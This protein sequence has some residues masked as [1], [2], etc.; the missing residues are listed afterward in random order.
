MAPYSGIGA[1]P[2]STAVREG[3]ECISLCVLAMCE[4]LLGA[5]P[6]RILHGLFT[7]AVEANLCLFL[8]NQLKCAFQC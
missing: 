3:R 4:V 2:H 6:Y 5:F 7:C 1:R 8:S